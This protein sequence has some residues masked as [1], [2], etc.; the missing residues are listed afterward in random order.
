MDQAYLSGCEFFIVIYRSYALC[1]YNDGTLF[2]SAVM[3]SDGACDFHFLA[4]I[5][6]KVLR[7]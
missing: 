4:Y 5:K 2:V 7:F 1:L 6:G 3:Y